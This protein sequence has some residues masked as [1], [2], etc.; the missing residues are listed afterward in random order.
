LVLI[1]RPDLSTQLLHDDLASGLPEAV[2]AA[3][4]AAAAPLAPPPGAAGG[5]AAAALG[6]M[7]LS[8]GQR[9][10]LA[11]AWRR[12][13][14]A[15]E[16]RAQ[17]KQELLTA[18]RQGF[19]QV[20]PRRGH[21]APHAAAALRTPLTRRPACTCV[22]PHASTCL[23]APML[24]LPAA[25]WQ[26]IRLFTCLPVLPAPTVLQPLQRAAPEDVELGK[27]LAAQ[28][29]EAMEALRLVVRQDHVSAVQLA[30]GVRKVGGRTAAAPAQ[31]HRWKQPQRLRVEQGAGAPGGGS[32]GGLPGGGGAPW[33][34][35]GQARLRRWLSHC[36]P[37]PAVNQ[38]AALPSP[39]LQLLS[40]LQQAR[41][42]LAAWP[43]YP[44]PSK[45]AP[46][47]LEQLPQQ[48][49]E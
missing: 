39:S 30:C 20:G 13:R 5:W 38:A 3:A 46:Q 49:P 28:G 47:L 19:L 8:G 4:A 23:L 11:G 18:I 29:L 15:A 33:G 17:R 48:G 27:P 35:A 21:P 22:V 1:S 7:Q 37:G 31:Q 44:D 43:R 10:A 40:P 24:L 32:S 36:S 16:Q 12:H 41:L 2:A 34:R 9:D 25:F 45:W 14:E 6:A 26:A 42:A